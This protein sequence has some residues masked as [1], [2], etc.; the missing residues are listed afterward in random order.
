VNN[1][2]P[3]RVVENLRQ[4]SIPFSDH[5][6]FIIS[7]VTPG[8]NATFP[9][10]IGSDRGLGVLLLCAALY[11]PGAESRAGKVITGLY[12]RLGNDI[13][14]LNRIPFA[15]LQKALMDLPI[16][17][18]A[19]EQKRI[20]GILRSVCDF[21]YETG[22]LE[23]WLSTTSDWETC[24]QRISEQIFWMGRHS[25]WR[26]KARYFLWL[27]SFQKEFGER[28]PQAMRFNWSV[29]EGHARFS[30]EILG[31]KSSAGDA[32]KRLAFFADFGRKI[33]PEK[34][35]VLFQPLDAYLR[36]EKEHGYLCR[37]IQGG[38]SRCPLKTFCPTA[39]YLGNVE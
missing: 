29:G 22:S 11:R 19:E 16:S 24:A 30:R 38:C 8:E 36:P 35:W 32:E 5:K 25:P 6:P 27:T 28:Y 4:Y 21:F 9:F 23:K 20:P 33:F 13:F 14:K 2:L 3:A 10:E 7:A 26:S 1:A 37:K 31:K 18:D 34:S 15:A 39:R 17:P 12:Q